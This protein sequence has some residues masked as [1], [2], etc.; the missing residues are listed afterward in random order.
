M[1]VYD[2]DGTIYAGDST[3]DFFWYAMKRYPLL[4]RYVPLQVWGF[5]MYAL[6]R[7]TKTQLKEYFFS[8]LKG[9]NASELA[10]E[11]WDRNQHRLYPWYQEVRDQS[12]IVISASP[13]FL[14]RPIC[15]RLDIENLIA[16]EVDS[17]TGKFLGENCRGEEKVRRLNREFG[18]VSIGAFYSDSLSDTPLAILA[19]NAF[20]V[21]DGTVQPWPFQEQK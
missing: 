5:G 17:K 11:F 12:C 16:S 20:L 7:I 8:F 14:L 3:V 1:N 15:N 4:L 2:F 9:I 10:E 18:E 6:K 19:K 21:K 13:E